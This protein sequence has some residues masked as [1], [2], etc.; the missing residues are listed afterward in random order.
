MGISTGTKS[1]AGNGD[2]EEMSPL[3][4]TG[5]VTGKILPRGDG[6]GGLL[7]EGEFPVAIAKDD[8]FLEPPFVAP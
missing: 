1:P 5:A 3:M 8:R 6:D 4:F 2:G 7:P